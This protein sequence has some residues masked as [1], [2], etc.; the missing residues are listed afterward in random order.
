MENTVLS[1]EPRLYLFGISFYLWWTLAR[2]LYIKFNID[3]VFVIEFVY[4]TSSKLSLSLFALSFFFF[5]KLHFFRSSCLVFFRL[6]LS[7]AFIFVVHFAFFFHFFSLR[8]FL[9]R[10]SGFF[11]FFFLSFRFSMSFFMSFTNILLKPSVHFRWP[12]E[13]WWHY[14]ISLGDVSYTVKLYV[15]WI[16][17]RGNHICK[18]YIVLHRIVVFLF[19][20]FYKLSYL[21]PFFFS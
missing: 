14:F 8:Y 9:C 15:K 7:P 1:N 21:F 19:S 2:C 11:G 13:S 6:F 12:Y 4:F 20:F 5:Y 18:T 16:L 17:Q 3:F 10:S